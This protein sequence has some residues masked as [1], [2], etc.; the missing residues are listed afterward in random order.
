MTLST[1]AIVP[2]RPGS[3]K[4]LSIG[5]DSSRPGARLPATTNRVAPATL[6]A[7]TTRQRRDRSRPS[8]SSR[9][10]KV[11]PNAIAGA[12]P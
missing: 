6:V 2:A 3:P 1:S 5:F 12:H 4:G 9:A 11:T 7:T 10:G 8:G